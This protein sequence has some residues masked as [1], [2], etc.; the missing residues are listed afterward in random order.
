MARCSCHF[1]FLRQRFDRARPFHRF[2]GSLDQDRR[3]AGA[4]GVPLRNA[5]PA[6]GLKR[7]S[8]RKSEPTLTEAMG[9]HS[10]KICPSWLGSCV[11]ARTA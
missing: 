9:M 7:E 3:A 6:P 5:R 2:D 10:Q 8:S 1:D 4:G 11:D